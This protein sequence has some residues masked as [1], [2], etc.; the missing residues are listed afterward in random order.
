ME[1][2]K[3]AASKAASTIGSVAKKALEGFEA[4]KQPFT[5]YNNIVKAAKT[6]EA[7]RK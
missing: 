4:L 6:M 2:F 1:F 7:K 3:K 5:L